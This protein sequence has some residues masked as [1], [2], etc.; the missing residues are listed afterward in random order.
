M[1][2]RVR[3]GWAGS[4]W[5]HDGSNGRRGGKR[6]FPEIFP[7]RNTGAAGRGSHGREIPH[8]RRAPAAVPDARRGEGGGSFLCACDAGGAGRLHDG[9]GAGPGPGSRSPPFRMQKGGGSPAAAP[10]DGRFPMRPKRVRRA[11]RSM[12]SGA[13]DR[14]TGGS[15]GSNGRR[16]RSSGCVCDLPRLR[17]LMRMRGTRRAR[18]LQTLPQPYSYAAYLTQ[19]F[20]TAAY[21]LQLYPYTE[22]ATAAI[23][24]RYSLRKHIAYAHIT[25][26][27]LCLPPSS[28]HIL[29]PDPIFPPSHKENT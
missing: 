3:R 23:L 17:A 27:L 15:D 14:L 18:Y 26:P 5:L 8:A 7:T 16:G 25:H 28:H 10:P 4:V 2:L 22:Y 1:L 19:I 29:N 21:L 20:S 6:V 11:C 24:R 9:S 12:G 13:G